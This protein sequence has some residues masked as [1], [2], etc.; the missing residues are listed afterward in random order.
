M[1]NGTGDTLMWFRGNQPP[2]N[3]KLPRC[4]WHANPAVS[5]SGRKGA[6]AKSRAEY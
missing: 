5:A 2:K 1:A 4:K 3:A 6:L